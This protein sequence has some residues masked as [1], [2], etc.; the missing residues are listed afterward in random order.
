MTHLTRHVPMD[1]DLVFDTERGS[2]NVVTRLVRVTSPSFLGSGREPY[3]DKP[4]VEDVSRETLS[5]GG[6]G[7]VSHL[8]TVALLTEP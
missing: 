3:L 1:A 8:R 6:G 5:R 4:I 7:M 2:P